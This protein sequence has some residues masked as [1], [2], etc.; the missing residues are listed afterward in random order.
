MICPDCNGS[1]WLP[2]VDGRGPRPCERCDQRGCI[3]DDV[4]SEDDL[5]LLWL[6]L[7]GEG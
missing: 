1:G 3:E 2:A 7:G 6:D 5:C 4:N